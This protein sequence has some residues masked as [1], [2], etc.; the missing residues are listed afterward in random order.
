MKSAKTMDISYFLEMVDI[1][2]RYGSNLRKYHAEWKSR[3][4]NENFFFWLDHGEAKDLDLPN[5]SRKRLDDM[6]VRYLNREERMLYEVVVDKKGKLVWRKDNV[7]VDTTDAWRDSV[8]GIVRIDDPAPLW[9][10]RPA[11]LKGSSE[12]SGIDSDVEREVATDA[13]EEAKE[14]KIADGPAAEKGLGME[15][16]KRHSSLHDMFRIPTSD[17]K[18][19]QKKPQ[20]KKKKQLW[21]FVFLPPC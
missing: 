9:A 5:C 4:T 10:D 15:K 7:R 11:F 17:N 2:H 16:H 8:E 3:P 1:K 19:L 21:I 20:A 12:S 14:N 6:Q 13:E 18:K